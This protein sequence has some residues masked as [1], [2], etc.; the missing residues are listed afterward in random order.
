MYPCRSRASLSDKRPDML[1]APAL[2]SCNTD[3]GPALHQWSGH[4]REVL[5]GNPPG[6]T[7]PEH[8]PHLLTCFKPHPLGLE[9]LS[10]ASV[11]QPFMCS[12]RVLS[13]PEA[14]R[15]E[16]A[17]LSFR[18]LCAWDTG[19]APGRYSRLGAH[20]YRHRLQWGRLPQRTFN[21]RASSI[22]FYFTQRSVSFKTSSQTFHASP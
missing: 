11:L 17:G 21:L 15:R 8:F 3:S 7:M 5:C 12:L 19:K 18:L 4:G 10:S 16:A 1:V 13:P 14:G 2:P 6:T 9:S 22:L 20:R